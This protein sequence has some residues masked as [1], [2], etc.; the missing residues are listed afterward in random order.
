[1]FLDTI[2]AFSSFVKISE[3]TLSTSFLE[4]E[5]AISSALEDASLNCWSAAS[6]ASRIIFSDSCLALIARDDLSS[7]ALA[8]VSS[9]IF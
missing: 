4:I 7:S 2:F 9:I 3:I 8:F 6:F 5:S 1:M